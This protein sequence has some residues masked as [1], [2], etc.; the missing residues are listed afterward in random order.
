MQASGG[1]TNGVKKNKAELEKQLRKLVIRIHQ[2]I[3]GHGPSEVWVKINSNVGTFYCSG[4]LTRIEEYLLQMEGGEE[5][6]ISLRKEIFQHARQRVC[7]EVEFIT[8][9]KVSG[10]TVNF[11]SSS[12]A[13]FGAILFDSNIEEISL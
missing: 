6:I 1:D 4:H 5:R 13:S 2:D 10:I 11:C 9:V 12:N 7:N 3:F 8:G